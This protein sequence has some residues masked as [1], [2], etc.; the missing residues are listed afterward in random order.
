M[1]RS[2]IATFA[3]ALVIAASISLGAVGLVTAEYGASSGEDLS[4][5]RGAGPVAASTIESSSGPALGM[6][7]TATATTQ[8]STNITNEQVLSGLSSPTAIQ[9]LPD[10]RMLVLQKNGVIYIADPETGESAVYM[11]ISGRV[12]TR[13]ERGLLDITLDPNFGT[14]GYF[15]VY[16]TNSQVSN[17]GT[18][19]IAR[20][21]HTE[22]SGG[23]SSDGD[24]SSEKLIWENPSVAENCCHFGGGLDI[25]PDGK[26]YLTTGEE[27]EGEQ[28]Q[29]LSKADGK[30]IRVN[31]DG[32]I[33]V[34]NPFVDDADALDSIWALGLR[35]PFRAEWDQ[36]TERLFIG[37]VGGNNNTIAQEDVHIGQKG[38]NYGWPECQGYCDNPD[39]TDP[40]YSYPHDG[41]GA[42][43]TGGFVYRGNQFPSEYSGAYILGDYVDGWIK[44]LTFNS[45]GGVES[46]N[47]ISTSAG[48][49]VH[50]AQGPNGSIYYADIADGTVERLVYS[51][52]NAG[53]EIQTASASPTSG[54]PPL[55]VNFTATATDPDGDS[56]SYHWVFGDGSETDGQN[57]SHTYSDAG[58]YTA[59][60]EVS[61]GEFTATSDPIRIVAGT[62]PNAT[63]TAPPNESLFRAGDA[64][65]F[66]GN[67]TDSEDGTLDGTR[68]SWT[69]DFLHNEHTHPAIDDETGAS[70]TYDVPTSGHDYNDDTGYEMTLTVTDSDGLTDSDT[71]VVYPDK[72]DLTF[73]TNPG[74][75]D[76]EFD[77]I[78]RTAPYTHDSLVN[79]NHTLTAPDQC[80]DNTRYVFQNWSDGGAQSH[81]IT[82]PESAT[83]YTANY[84]AVG[85]CSG[86]VP[87]DPV[88]RLESDQGVS[89]SGSTVTN[90]ADQSGLGNDLSA[91]GDPAL[92][93]NALGGEPVISFDGGD[94]A[95]QRSGLNG[96]STGNADRTMLYVVRYN[97]TGFGGLAY[98]S[99]SCNNAFGTIVS[100]TGELTVQGWCSGND[101]P[102]GT[103]GTDAGWMTQSVVLSGDSFTHYKNG[104][105]IDSGTQT[106]DT[107]DNMLVLGGELTPPPYLDM[108]VAAVYVYNRSLSESE[109]L[110]LETYVENKY[111]S[112]SANEPPTANDDSASVDQG[113]S[114]VVDVLANDS[115]TDGSLNPS[116]VTIQQSPANGTVSV[117]SST[118]TVNYT[119]DGSD[120]ASDT[121]TYTVADD[122]GAVSNEATVSIDV[123]ITTNEAPTANDDSAS[124]E[125][126]QSVTV[127]VLANDTDADGSLNPSSVTIQQ[128]PTSGTAAVDE[129][130]GAVTYTHDGSDT[131]SD[132][133]TYT[134]ADD[135]GATS[136][137][138]T[139]DITVTTSD[140]TDPVPADPVLRLESDQ[141]VS[142]SGSTVTSWAD[143]SG[144][145]NDLSASGDPALVSNAL[146]GEPV[147]SFDGGD[148]ALQRSGLNG[149]ATGSADRTMLY[150]VRYNETGFGGLAYG[151]ASCNNAFGTIVSDTG[152][153]AVQGW[154]SGNDYPSGTQGTDA[155]WMTQSVVLSGDSFT[156]YKNGTAID[157]GT[158]TFDTTDN[159]LVLGGEL[160]PPP[161]LD[162]DVAAVY[163]YNRSL[164]ETERS[165]LETYVENKYFT[166]SANQAPTANDDSGSVDQ[167]QSVTVDVLANDTDS[168]GSLDPSSVTIQQPPANGTVSGHSSTGAVNY[169]HDGSDAASDSFTYTVE[170]D[171]GA[172][173]NEATVG[174]DVTIATNEAP[175]AN[176]DSASV[177]QGDS[178]VVDVL[179]NDTDS[180]GSLNA[181]SVTVQQSPANGSVSV[182]A[183]TGAVNYTHDGSDAASDTFTYTVDDDDGA[184]SNEATVSIDV[185]VTTSE[186]LP[187]TSGLVLH[188]ESDQGVSMSGS[189]VT[190]WADQSG[191]GNDLSASGDPA[192]VSNALGGEPV[193]SFDGGDDILQRTNTLTGFATGS[194]DRTM[195]Y[196][197]RYN[198]TGFGGL[199]Y[200]S[201]NCNNA[202]GTIVS[203]VGDLTVQGWCSANDYPSD[204]VGTDAGWMTQSV[205]LSGDSF[206]HYKNGTAIDSG[207]QTF[208]TTDNNL[209]LGGE[210]TP[211]PY[212]DMDVAAVYVYN[213]SLSET[214]RSD[215]E[216]YV[217]NKYFGG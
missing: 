59:Y 191:L 215:L 91:S 162:M 200:G 164:S 120:A 96:F 151:S 158:Q 176:D 52:D 58:Q 211:P 149:F 188:L 111:F 44:Y 150:V 213:R 122:D 27:F 62:P 87:A 205:V 24:A 115:D 22:G 142:T 123:A 75:L 177:T 61:D 153:L 135:D 105:A 38:A 118:G 172:V 147:I 14:N 107:T 128:S 104:T 18:N 136:N 84:E 67:G 156:H 50:L 202:F 160:T 54:A 102:S 198:E 108:D 30:V 106:Y 1:K 206:T 46:V 173:S 19:R 182:D 77:D 127:D 45:S 23:L 201:A 148:D 11:D 21:T 70:V 193:I 110:D 155:G 217:Q 130:T 138:A 113:Q 63:I 88:L 203:D 209:V 184:T 212:L 137:E 4:A 140:T 171:D 125:Q 132:S 99:A 20:F 124:V 7:A 34:D 68:F 181:S 185:D 64:I 166:E 183:S 25:G 51:A 15:Y 28:A 13:G 199:A 66:E 101:Y 170:D 197:V 145:G 65:T 174:I 6:N 55:A 48:A 144:L 17:P 159:N 86:S 100:D 69:M 210:M 187:V 37:E 79:F 98:G 112:G 119:H 40:V 207:T 163:I 73:R 194:A 60:L 195:L 165:D 8:T 114:V 121:F 109:R 43:V 189:T 175:T 116:S 56:L 143:Q 76:F 71:V 168:D 154:C 126:G 214:E 80:A 167:G 29:N 72:A 32:T 94:D 196:V 186:G 33:P 146:G 16:Y 192:L 152:E 169:T 5:S 31:R 42:S 208:D 97:E 179:A 133:F 10:G 92:V 36:Q 190:S 161:Y 53:P 141:G 78:S 49:V 12:K 103:Q 35:N 93:S 90:W 83:T 82:T 2:A 89:T 216:T 157:S 3:S 85:D 57:V 26:L 178:V 129:S 180:D 131:T 9:F 41:S 117:N 39:Y 81:T 204:V 74:G 47:T 139:V 134:V 95:L